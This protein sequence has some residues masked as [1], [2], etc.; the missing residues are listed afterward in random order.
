MNEPKAIFW[1]ETNQKTPRDV[2]KG[3]HKLYWFNCNICLHEFESQL[4]NITSKNRRWCPFC[5]KRKLCKDKTCD[6]CKKNSFLSQPKAIFWSEENEKKPREVF[7]SSNDKFLFNCRNGHE[8]ESALNNIKK[9]TWCPG[10]NNKTEQKLYDWLTNKESGLSPYQAERPEPKALYHSDDI[11][12]QFKTLWC[13]NPETNRFL[14]FDF[15]IESLNLIIELDGPQHFRQVLN[16][17]NPVATRKGD[18]YKMKQA[19]L[20]GYSVIRILQEDVWQDQNN[21]ETNLK[22]A[23]QDLRPKGLVPKIIYICENNEYSVYNR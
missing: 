7:K 6:F 19:L 2:L 22:S 16:W 17:K 23:I 1:S 9:G 18:I 11:I 8:F 21:W 13:Q 15:L 12:K 20:N 4:N 14:P 3:S 10:C 5:A